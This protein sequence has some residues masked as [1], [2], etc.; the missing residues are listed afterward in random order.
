MT[1]AE[2]SGMRHKVLGQDAAPRLC[3]CDQ[4]CRKPSEPLATLRVLVTAMPTA[5]LSTAAQPS[6][7]SWLHS[8]HPPSLC[9]LPRQQRRAGRAALPEASAGT[10]ILLLSK[11]TG[12]ESWLLSLSFSLAKEFF[13]PRF[14]TGCVKLRQK[15]VVPLFKNLL[16]NLLLLHLI[17]NKKLCCFVMA[18]I[19]FSASIPAESFSK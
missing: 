3:V 18:V 13:S 10:A 6:R 8:L 7:L 19:P 17:F 16:Q 5:C 11:W 4:P 9:R 15:L 12:E 14:C 1:S 2:R